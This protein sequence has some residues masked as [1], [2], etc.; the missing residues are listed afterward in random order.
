MDELQMEI[1]A[2]LLDEVLLRGRD[3]AEQWLKI[4][5]QKNSK[6]RR[7]IKKAREWFSLPGANDDECALYDKIINDF[8]FHIE[9]DETQR[10]L[11]QFLE[12]F[13]PDDFSKE[14]GVDLVLAILKIAADMRQW[15][16]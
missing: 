4:A 3:F 14:A 10:H 9:D 5:Q 7:F 6:G 12:T 16:F 1:N 8:T 15:R 13:Q 2:F 11:I